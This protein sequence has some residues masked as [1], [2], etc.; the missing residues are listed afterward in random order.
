MTICDRTFELVKEQLLQTG[1]TGP[2]A[3]SC[4]DTKLFSALR[5]YWDGEQQ[6]HFI[7]GGVNGLIYPDW[8]HRSLPPIL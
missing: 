8:M 6:S 7:V 3:L 4:D 2:T 5:L 1:Y